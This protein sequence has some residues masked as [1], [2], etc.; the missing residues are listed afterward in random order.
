M[1]NTAI[2]FDLRVTSV[3]T[4]RLVLPA[5]SQRRACACCE[6]KVATGW[7]LANGHS[8]CGHCEAIVARAGEFHGSLDAFAAHVQRIDE[9]P[10][11]AAARKYLA[12]NF[13][14]L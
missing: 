13:R 1:A 11:N 14:W 2:R 6:T 9:V 8:V 7:V 5:Q 10:L 12:A 4:G 3:R